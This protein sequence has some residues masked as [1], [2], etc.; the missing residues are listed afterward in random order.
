M[1]FKN[2]EVVIVYDL[3]LIDLGT[4]REVIDDMGFDVFLLFFLVFFI[5]INDV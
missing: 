5:L 2:E 1:L 3:F 4:F